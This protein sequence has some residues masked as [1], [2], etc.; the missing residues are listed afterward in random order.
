MASRGLGDP[1]TR[2]RAEG[3]QLPGAVRP[4]DENTRPKVVEK[5]PKAVGIAF[6][7]AVRAPLMAE[8]TALAIATRFLD[9]WAASGSPTF[10]L[11]ASTVSVDG[12]V[13]LE[14][15]ASDYPWI[16][17]AFMAGLRAF[18]P[19][20][21]VRVPQ[22]RSFCDE[23]LALRPELGAIERFRD[24]LW[25]DGA[26]GFDV[27]VQSS[28]MEA[29]DATVVEE[30]ARALR[31]GIERPADGDGV[32]PGLRVM[33]TRD[34]EAARRREEL[35]AAR[36]AALPPLPRH[37]P[38]GA[39]ERQALAAACE[40]GVGW[41]EA[42]VDAALSVP[43]LRNAMPAQR[44][45]RQAALLLGS[46]V[47]ERTVDVVARLTAADDAYGRALATAID[48]T[49]LGRR[50]ADSLPPTPAGSASLAR[51]AAVAPARL[52]GG[53]A[54]GLVDRA[55]D[56]E[57]RPWVIEAVRALGPDRLGKA[58]NVGALTPTQC[59]AFAEVVLGAGGGA[60][61]L[62][63][64]LQAL[65]PDA[66]ARLYASL[67]DAHAAALLDVA[68]RILASAPPP[69]VA[70]LL[71]RLAGMAEGKAGLV[72]GRY[73]L[74][75]KAQ[76]WPPRLAEKVTTAIARRR[77]FQRDTLV[78]LARDTG[79]PALLRIAALR[80]LTDPEALS[81]ALAWRLSEMMDPPEVKAVLKA[82]RAG[83]KGET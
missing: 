79:F 61:T 59:A 14:M 49:E 19:R 6:D 34:L 25:G 76:T 1:P 44:L 43:S 52:L 56:P 41:A 66:A 45:G 23:L 12:V 27:V 51:L 3:P 73:L 7:A 57:R 29:A 46:R 16:L 18:R 69:E 58:L 22:L 31:L 64:V 26:E 36:A 11:Q 38:M 77:E 74:A 68:G 37:A 53:V 78:P 75:S 13:A 67:A 35:R 21:D 5:G 81:A 65:P 82:R 70:P 54:L 72:L 9:L 4:G 80:A 63:P 60:T 33:S 8:A 40:S 17:P 83:A 50:V 55:A 15:T 24:W 30:A 48:D 47:D 10:T 2:P 42:L 20:P 32:A 39:E 71:E 28:F 62:G